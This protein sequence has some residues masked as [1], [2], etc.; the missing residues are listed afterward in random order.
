MSRR[1][2]FDDFVRRA[3]AKHDN[4]Y[5]YVDDGK[6]GGARTHIVAVCPQHGE[7]T[8]RAYNHLSGTGCS[9]CGAIL[10]GALSAAKRKGAPKPKTVEQ[11]PFG[12]LGGL[13]KLPFWN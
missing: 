4:R 5:T 13:F 10:G 1:T 2:T 9:R 11:P 7:F 8:Q 3:R 12:A 6:W